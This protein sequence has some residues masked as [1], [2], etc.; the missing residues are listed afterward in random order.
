MN[1]CSFTDCDK[2]VFVKKTDHGPLC[3]GHYAQYK[4]GQPLAPLRG[5]NPRSATKDHAICPVDDCDRPSWHKTGY[6]QSHKKQIQTGDEPSE[7]RNYKF[8]E[9]NNCEV[10]GCD[11][12]SKSRGYCGSH[13]R[14]DWGACTYPGCTRKMYN[15]R[16]SYCASHYNQ[17]RGLE[18][19]K[20]V[21]LSDVQD[22][23]LLRPV[24]DKKENE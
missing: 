7:I 9:G 14:Q 22:N 20:S 1:S 21:T 23:K 10:A 8:Q 3:N 15:R 11:K 24:K 2:V 18:K 16:T 5:Y 13:Y 6:C 12:P 19:S 4:K 17:F